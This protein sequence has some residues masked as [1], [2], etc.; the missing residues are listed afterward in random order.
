MSN[1]IIYDKD[2]RVYAQGTFKQVNKLYDKV[3][4][5]Y[6]NRQIFMADAED[7]KKSKCIGSD[8]DVTFT[9]HHNQI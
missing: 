5:A 1:K 3:V 4:K 2:G 9:P 7:H 8:R 6:P